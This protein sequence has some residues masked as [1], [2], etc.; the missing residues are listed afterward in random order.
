[1]SSSEMFCLV[2]NLNLII[3]PLIPEDNEY[4]EFYLT[5]KEILT[6]V[7]STS[8]TNLTHNILETTIYEYLTQLKQLFPNHFKPKHHFLVQYPR[9]MFQFGPLWKFSCL[10]FESK[11]QEGKQISKSTSS[12]V[13]INRTIAIKHQLFLN[14]RFMQTTSSNSIF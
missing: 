4:W 10:R 5:L 2:E 6:I 7:S 8:I 12:R 13:N 11:N 9:F 3:G 1:M 14:L